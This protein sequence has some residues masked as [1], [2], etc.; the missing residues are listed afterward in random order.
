MTEKIIDIQVP[1]H[2]IL[3]QLG[4]G[5]M[6]NVYLAIQESM[7]R[8]VALKVM[9]PSLG[10]ED[11]SFSERFV[12]EAR[13]IAKLSHPH[14]NA[15]YDVGV[16]GPHHYFS[17]EYITGGDLRSRIR[18]GLAPKTA[19][20]IAYQI[21][22]ALAFAH[23]KG[24]VHRDVKP[25]NV[26]F[27][28]NGTAVLTDFG[29]AKTSDVAG[30]MTATGT[31][32][33]TPHYMSPEQAMGREI[34]MRADIYSLGVMLFEMLTGKVPYTGDSA[35]SVGIKHL[36]EPIP[37]L[38]PPLNVYQPLLE[39]FLAK[40]PADRFQTGEETMTAIEAAG[41]NA[42]TNAMTGPV[43]L[44]R[45]VVVGPHA[46][47]QTVVTGS[48]SKIGRYALAAAL[49]VPLVAGGIYFAVR[50]PEPAPIASAIPTP[51]IK[52]EEPTPSAAQIE[53]TANVA[54]IAQLLAEADS[55]AR[56]GQYVEPSE[57]AA[58]PKYRRVLELESTNA[59][60]KRA[61]NE[62]AGQLVTNAERAIEKNDL[63]HAETLLR[64]AEE[65]D[66][67][68]PMLFSR[69]LALNEYRQKQAVS[70]ATSARAERK[71]ETAKP[72]PAAPIRPAPVITEAPKQSVASV[73]DT[74]AREGRE[75]EHKLQGVLARF[76]DLVAPAS[77]SA[78]RAELAHELLAEA[79]RLAPDDNRVRALP[80]QLADAYL[81]LAT[82]KVETKAYQDAEALIRRGLESRPDHRQLQNLQKEVA[83]RKNPKRQVF[84][85]F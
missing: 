53:A 36:K 23:S 3:R 62:I 68:H 48:T 43:G 9:L 75:R 25:E 69:R 31:V 64:Q 47:T 45:T 58:V 61:L 33:G 83:E 4:R 28:E 12:R 13:I 42:N 32:M 11:P 6:A 85:S 74:R 77:L 70:A 10:A 29:I 7:D 82:T 81:K 67:T 37:V 26:L 27:R 46:T 30:N 63:N 78:T 24:Y 59:R 21:A 57:T 17:M 65:T 19:L 52:V 14:V 40:E 8:E 72:V 22:N 34:D 35:V 80:T 20:A 56:A 54:R 44:E 15:V 2:R 51:T 41:H 84:G 1:G 55:A 5:G 39:R 79:T 50:K 38:S 73:E 76:H 16:A 66:A 49:L 60:A 18:K 71:A